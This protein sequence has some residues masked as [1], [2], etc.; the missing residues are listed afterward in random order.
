MVEFPVIDERCNG[1]DADAVY[2]VGVH[3]IGGPLQ[4]YKNPSEGILLES[5]VKFA[6]QNDDLN[7]VVKGD[8]MGEYTLPPGWYGVTEPTVVPKTNRHGV[9]VTVVGTRAPSKDAD[10]V[11]LWDDIAR[12]NVMKSRIF[13]LDGDQLDDGPVWEIDLPFHMP[14]GLHSSFVEWKVLK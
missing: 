3:S 4:V 8:V 7:N 9:Y 14:Y 2:C 11:P 10:R 5:V 13:V 6:L 12:K 1:K